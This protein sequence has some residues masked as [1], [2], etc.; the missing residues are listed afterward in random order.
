MVIF[1]KKLTT[2]KS[3][4]ERVFLTLLHPSIFYAQLKRAATLGTPSLTIFWKKSQCSKFCSEFKCIKNKSNL[5][6]DNL[7]K[8]RQLSVVPN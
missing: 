7:I 3:I 6:T 4:T 8:I 5:L 2:K 1:T